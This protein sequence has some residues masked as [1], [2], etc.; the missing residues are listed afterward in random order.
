MKNVEEPLR[1]MHQRLLMSAACHPALHPQHC[2]DKAG[3]PKRSTRRAAATP[4][5]HEL[6][7]FVSRQH[8]E[9]V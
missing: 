1:L 4:S 3:P 7:D 9:I 8:K 6:P 5:S 2:R